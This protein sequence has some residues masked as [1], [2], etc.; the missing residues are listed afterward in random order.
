[1]SRSAPKKFENAP[2]SYKLG[3]SLSPSHHF[4]QLSSQ[5][6][7]AANSCISKH[8]VVRDKMFSIE[9]TKFMSMKNLPLYPSTSQV[10]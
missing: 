2:A 9:D 4:S 6:S 8:L 1:M 10:S 3:S 5:E 7:Q